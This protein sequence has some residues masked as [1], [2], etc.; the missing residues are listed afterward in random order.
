MKIIL[1]SPASSIHTVQW[2]KY[3]SELGLDVHVISQHLA[4]QDFPQQIT[5]HILPF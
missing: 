5:I 2:A 4:S 3:L 1:L